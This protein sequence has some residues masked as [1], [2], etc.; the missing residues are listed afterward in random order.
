MAFK[1]NTV[2]HIGE[3]LFV[4]PGVPDLVTILGSLRPGVEAI[5]LDRARPA[6]RQIGTAL[7]DRDVDTVHVIAHGAPGRVS[8]AAGTWSAETIDDEA[9]DFAAIGAALGV[10]GELRLW[11]CD[12]GADTA[13]A[14]FVERLAQ[15]TG[16]D[17]ATAPGRVGAAALGGGWNLTSHPHL[18]PSQPPLTAAGG[19]PVSDVLD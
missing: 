2:P 11:S 13:G 6:S 3:I 7:A 10:G 5:V 15:A 18:A 9:A 14:L 12:T 4:D 8:F 19:E 1:T 17:I 16:V